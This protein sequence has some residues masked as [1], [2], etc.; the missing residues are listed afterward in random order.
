MESYLR[1]FQ[2]EEQKQE[3]V[4]AA[5]VNPMEEYLRQQREEEELSTNVQPQNHQAPSNSPAA[6]GN[7]GAWGRPPPQARQQAPP[8]QMRPQAPQQQYRPQT[9]PQAPPQSQPQ[10]SWGGWG[11]QS[12]QPANIQ[13]APPVHAVNDIQQSM[14]DVSLD[15]GMVI[16]YF[17]LT[18]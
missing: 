14:S 7:Q 4:Q 12:Q 6:W 1:E 8:P 9:R 10:K 17:L 13:Q 16:I 15:S 11:A 2:E 5:P 3:K 18:C